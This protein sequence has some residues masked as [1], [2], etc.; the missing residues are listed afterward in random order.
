MMVTLRRRWLFVTFMLVALGA[1]GAGPPARTHTGAEPEDLSKWEWYHEVPLPS[2]ASGLIDFV[3]PPDVFGRSRPDLGDLRL[4]DSAGKTVPYALRIRAPRDVQEPLAHQRTFNRAVNPDRSL[5]ISIDLGE[6]PPQHNEIAVQLAGDGYGR[7]L[8]LE[9]SPDGKTWSKLLDH[10][11]VVHLKVGDQLIDQHRFSYSPSRFR[12]L[13][14]AL[15]PDRVLKNDEPQIKSVQVYHSIRV[16]GEEM[17]HG[18][19]LQ[20]REPVRWNNEYASAW[21]IDLGEEGVPCERLDIQI[22]E[23]DFVRPFMVER[24]EPGRSD[25]QVIVAGELRPNDKNRS[26]TV[27]IILQQTVF[28]RWLRLTIQDARN[29]PL[30]IGNVWYTAAVRQVVFRVPEGTQPPLRLYHGNPMATAP[31][32]DFAST[33]PARLDP[34][35]DRIEL[36]A[37]ERNPQYVPPPKPWTERWP[38]LVDAVLAAAC[39]LLLAVLFVLA[40][41]AIRSTAARSSAAPPAC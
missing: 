33:L 20:P 41:R 38:Y 29:P 10:V 17:T 35:P 24:F 7:P 31:R 1:V 14:V 21:V 40:R 26:P 8:R 25:P 30:T 19:T 12:Y 13:R 4:I 5:E 39:A 16:H 6:A 22:E 18:A 15:K 37:L 28:A 36:G 11:Y 23:R 34:L 9:G 2:G 32:Y 27:P 3:M